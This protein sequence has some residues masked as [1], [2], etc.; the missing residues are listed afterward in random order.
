MLLEVSNDLTE[1]VVCVRIYFLALSCWISE[2]FFEY[3]TK[4]HAELLDEIRKSEV[5]QQHVSEKVAVVTGADGTI[6][7]EV[8]RLLLSMN[9]TVHAIVGDSYKAN[10]IF[11][12]KAG[13][14]SDRLRLYRRNF[15]R[16]KEII[17]LSKLIAGKSKGNISMFVGCAGV[18]LVRKKY[19]NNIESHL[20][21]NVLANALF[22]KALQECFNERTRVLLLGSSACRVAMVPVLESEEQLLTNYVGPYQ[23]YAYSKL[24]L[25]AYVEHLSSSRFTTAC[26]HPGVVP[27]GLYRNTNFFVK[28][29]TYIICP[30]FLRNGAFAALLVVHTATRND[31]QKGSYYEDTKRIPVTDRLSIQHKQS[32]ANAF[33]RIANRELGIAA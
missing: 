25:A 21:V 33:N 14:P 26:V 29:V 8:V 4:G 13:Y 18:M 32:L 30:F 10:E 3:F 23:S 24:A 9:F 31:L 1:W 5:N 2:I 19:I 17:A 20:S 6:G 7:R 12:G 16:N 27:S 22:I 28:L 15:E 11:H